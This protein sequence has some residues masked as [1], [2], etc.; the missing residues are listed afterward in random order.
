MTP[1]GRRVPRTTLP[2]S[3]LATLLTLAACG[4]GERGRAE[5]RGLTHGG[6]AVRG[7]AL[8]QR[9]GCGSCHVIPG[10][11][12][13]VGK[14]GPSLADFRERTFVAGVLPHSP[15]N[16]MKWIEDPPKVDSLT[17]MPRLGVS[18]GEARDIAAYLYA[19]DR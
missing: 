9:Y 10:V 15:D 11:A 4:R 7:H 12:G 13:A 3:L 5:A 14:V 17:A 16:L 8:V 2:A 19:L 6:D 18:H 1:L